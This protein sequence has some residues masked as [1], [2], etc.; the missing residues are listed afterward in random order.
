VDQALNIVMEHATTFARW[1]HIQTYGTPANVVNAHMNWISDNWVAIQD[2]TVLSNIIAANNLAAGKNKVYYQTAQPSLTGNNVGDQWVDIDD[3]YKLYTWSGSAWQITQD[4]KAAL[5]LAGTKIRSFVQGT[6]PTATS[7]GDIWVNTS[8]KNE[9]LRW[10]GSAWVSYRDLSIADADGKAAQAIANAATAQSTADGKV[11]T[12]FQTA[13][14]TGLVAGDVGDLWFDT[15]DGNKMYRWTGSAWVVSDDQRI[16]ATVTAAANAQ[17]VAD[18]KITTFYQ[19]AQPSSTGRTV[20]DLWVDTDDQNKL[21][22]WNGASWDSARDL[23][24]ASAANSAA[25]ALSAAQAAQSAADAAKAVA[26]GSIRTWYQSTAPTGLNNTTDVGDLWFDTDDGQ[27]YRWS[28]TAFVI[29]EDNS[30]AVALNAAQNAQTTA[31]GKITSYYQPGQPATGEVGDLWFDTDDKNKPYYCSN[32]APVTWTPVR[33][34]TIVDAQSTANTALTTANGKNVTYYQTAQPTGGTYILGDTWIDTDDGN[35]MYVYNGTTFVNAQDGAIGAASSL[36]ASKGKTIIQSATPSVADQLAQNLW[37]DTTNGLN[38]P[39]RWSGSA[40]VAVTDKVATDAASAAATAQARA[41]TAFNNAASAA[42]AAGNAQTTADGKNRTWYQ[43]SAPAGTGHKDGDLW[44]D[45]DDGNKLYL[46][47]GTPT[48]AWTVF[49]DGAISVAQTA[50]N[51]AATAASNA[52]TTANNAQ[53]AAATAD[54]KAV[55]AKSTADTAVTNAQTAQNA[56]NQALSDALAANNLAASKG[57]VLYQTTAP[58]G[59]DANAQTLWIDTTNG[60][61]TPKRWT[62]GTTWVTVTD[63]VAT[64]AAALASSK[65]KIL[66]QN[67]APTGA[68]AS[69]LTLWIDTTNGANTPMKWVSGTTWTAITDKVALDAAN[70]AASAATAASNAQGTANTA[71]TNAAT[72]QTKADQAF[73]NAAS[74]ATAAGN[75]QTTAN[76]KNRVWYQTTAPTGTGHTAGD[77]WFDTSSGNQPYTWVAGQNLWTSIRD[78]TIATAQ[79]KADSAYTVASGKNTTYYQTAQPTGGTYIKGDLWFDTDD[80]YKLYTHTGSAW[81]ATQDAAAAQAAAISAASADATSKAN[82]AQSAATAAAASDA[83]AKASAAQAAAISAAAADATTKADAAKAAAL[84]AVQNAENKVVNGGFELDYDGWTKNSA[85]TTQG[86]DSTVARSG[87]KSYYSTG[88]GELL[89][90]PFAVVVGS[91]WRYEWFYKTE[92]TF[93]NGSAGGLRIQKSSDNGATWSDAVTTSCTVNTNWTYQSVEYAVPAGVTHL[94][95]RIAFAY[96]TGPKVWM[97]DVR[98]I[99]VSQIKTLEAD[100]QTKATNAQNAAISAA[101]ADATAKADAAKAAAISAAAAD[102]TAKVATK[103]TSYYQTPQPSG[104]TYLK[105]DLW[106][107]TANNYKLYTYTGSAWQATQDAAAAQAAAISA[108]ATDAANKAATAQA[109]AISAAATDA[110]TK[111]TNAQTAAIAAAATDATTKS[112][113]AQM[114]AIQSQ[115]YSLNASFEDWTGTIPANYTTFVTNPTKETSIVLTGKNAVRFNCTDATTQR[116]LQFNAALAHAPYFEYL[117]IEL[118]VRLVSGTSFGGAGVLVDWGGMTGANRVSVALSSEIPT[119]TVGK[120][121]RLVKVIRKPATATGTF[122]SYSAWLMGQYGLGTQVIKDIVFDWINIRP[123]TNEEITAYGTPASIT[124]VNDIVVTKTK[125]WYQPTQPSLTGN[126]TGDLWFD[127]ANG[128]KPYVWNG[129]WTSAQDASIATAQSAAN[130]AQTAANGK[131]KVIYSTSA[132]SGTTGYI[133]GD[134]WFQRD[135]SNNIIGQWEFTTSWQARQIDNAVIANVNA[136]KINAGTIAAARIGAQTIDASKIFVGDLT[137]L[138]ADGNFSDVTKVNWVGSGTVT[139]SAAEPNRLR[140]VTAASGNND[141]ANANLIQVTAGEQFYGEV[142]VYGEPANVGGGGPNMHMAVSDNNGGMSWPTFQS[143]T[144]AA[145]SGNWTKLSGKI[146]MPANAKQAKVE[147]AV[148][149]S[150]D[151]VG[152]IYYFRNVSV[153]RMATGS[154]IVDGAIQAG[155]LIIGTGAI[156]NAQIADLSA[157][158]ITAGT[159]AAARLD[160]ETVK[161]KLIEASYLVATDIFA[162]NSITSA[163]GIFGTMDA[164]VINAGTIAAARLDAEVV[165]SKLIEASYIVATDIFAPNSITSASGI[166]GTMDASVINAGTIA[167]ARLDAETVKSKLIEASYIVATDIFAPNS[168]TSAS[169]IFGAM[170]ASV[171]N[172]GTIAAAR[173]DAETIKTKLIE[174]SLIDAADI[175][176]SGSITATNGIIASIDASKITVGTLAAARI[177]TKSLTADKMLITSTDNLIQEGDFSGSGASWQIATDT[178][179]N[180]GWAI[181]ATAGRNSLAAMVT[182]NSAT[183]QTSYNAVGAPTKTP[184]E[185]QADGNSAYRVTAWVKSTVSVPVSGALINARFRSSTGAYTIVSMPY[186]TPGTNTPA[187]MPT[188]GTWYEITGILTAPADCISVAFSISTAASFSTGT[189]TWDSVAA[190]RAST[191][192]LIVDG[193]VTATKIATGSITATNGIIASLDVSKVTA[194]TMSGSFISA[195]S[196]TVD[197]LVIS[198]TDNLIVESNFE[199]PTTPGSSWTRG[200]NQIIQTGGGRSGGNAMRLTGTTSQVTSFNLNNKVTVEQDHKFRVSMWVKANAVY[201]NGSVRLGVRPYIGTTTAADVTLFSNSSNSVSANYIPGTNAWTQISGFTSALP[202]GTTAV[203][204]FISSVAPSATAFIDFDAVTVSRAADGNLVVDGAMD[205]KTITGALIRSAVSG[206]RVQLDSSGIYGY[207]ANGANYLS[208]TAAG[209]SLTGLLQ[210]HGVTDDDLNPQPMTVVTG[211]LDM[212]DTSWDPIGMHFVRDGW[213]LGTYKYVPA[214]VFSFDGIDLQLESGINYNGDPSSTPPYSSINLTGGHTQV[215]GTSNVFLT[216]GTDGFVQIQTAPEGP[217]FVRLSSQDV[218]LGRANKTSTVYVRERSIEAVRYMQS[219]VVRSYPPHNAL[220]G[221]GLFTIDYGT[222]FYP[223]FFDV[224][225]NDQFWIRDTG[226]YNFEFQFWLQYTGGGQPRALFQRSNG[227]GGWETVGAVQRLENT[228][229]WEFNLTRTLYVPANTLFRLNFIQGSGTSQTWDTQL[230]ITKLR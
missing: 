154:L 24:I 109:N 7:I 33:D 44:F 82:A 166:F 209:L 168:I 118:D 173:L 194:G 38:T 182:T 60:A 191:G 170:D 197:K 55:T 195:K 139:V 161:A 57:K 180:A 134:T 130:T 129:A 17:Q 112:D 28:G 95:A 207:D 208:G 51:N 210:A 79:S 211:N 68:D 41:D 92:A 198:S 189:L 3:S 96:T 99:D 27:A 21:Y 135:A 227:A 150:A 184:I 193:A 23:S 133:A 91:T 14:P 97:D 153:R 20:G 9:M 66:F 48:L 169:G 218:Y 63:K 187:T 196:M 156:G 131:N 228:A 8:N 78:A 108:A 128:N 117:T 90:T 162:P 12:Y 39:K 18:S 40:W 22:R 160:A 146:T 53:T 101:A 34:G 126:T 94:R 74:A 151:A 59:A 212:P 137:N 61:N 77:L 178:P 205:A 220:W 16:A 190:T 123:A 35:K 89:G 26:D 175:L 30:I 88:G 171:I 10:S 127:T 159:I 93:V 203:E 15:D 111:A 115:A 105:G 5:D 124:A 138:A 81:Q 54:S 140:V 145:V 217:G 69:V 119:P 136:A 143:L 13:A 116:G 85:A 106:F 219:L 214:R 223:E 183:L 157:D 32:G 174:A 100:A 52:Q 73:A 201:G 110:S 50:A 19:T 144:R 36:A 225:T 37:I 224:P 192:E 226:V 155:S 4:S 67:T 2:Q 31:D 164:S 199:N 1:A 230:M 222:S 163:S 141:Q 102:A 125:T 43:T 158:K 103:N 6:A 80:N 120:W 46:W 216:T 147:L 204:F 176:V 49:Q 121:Y 185:F 56:A 72:A 75:A 107:D 122:T 167:A 213:A 86:I 45:T 142:W 206:A 11:A 58:T 83:T 113:L 42:T 149:F 165:K 172:A 71:V 152:N 221:P 229:L 62:S 215:H 25:T 65:G 202:A 114:I 76:G 70:A 148:G 186:T 181:N 98:L 188:A 177:G 87:S 132:A 47:K 29:I 179:T 84:T 104:G 64:D 200:T